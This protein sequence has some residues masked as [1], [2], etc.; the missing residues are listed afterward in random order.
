MARKRGWVQKQSTN[1][2]EADIYTKMKEVL[3]GFNRGKKHTTTCTALFEGLGPFSA[4]SLH[5]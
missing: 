4:I 3:M 1:K 2:V 5:I